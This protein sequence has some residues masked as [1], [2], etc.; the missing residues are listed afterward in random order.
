MPRSLLYE[1]QRRVRKRERRFVRAGWVPT[2][3]PAPSI[4]MVTRTTSN[5]WT[6]NVAL[7]PA[8]PANLQERMTKKYAGWIEPLIHNW[9]E[10][11]RGFQLGNKA[12]VDLP[13]D[14]NLT[15]SGPP[16]SFLSSCFGT[17]LTLFG[18]YFFN[19]AIHKLH[20]TNACTGV[21]GVGQELGVTLNHYAGFFLRS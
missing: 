9:R 18:E 17:L 15:R 21:A 6:H 5:G 2:L 1:A 13:G 4:C 3:T 11:T 10:V 12:H 14:S 7:V 19:T 8:S 20:F 16:Y